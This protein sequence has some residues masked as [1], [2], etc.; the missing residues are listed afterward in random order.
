MP[1][2]RCHEQSGLVAGGADAPDRAAYSVVER[3]PGVDDRR[4]ISGIVLVIRD[5]LRWPDAPKDCGP[6]KTIHNR[7]IRCSRPGAFNRIFA[8]LATKGGRPDRQMIDATHLK[9]HRT[10][11]SLLEQRLLPDV[12]DGPEAA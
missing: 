3:V 2:G 1:R 7:F 10:A 6:H 9:A 11:A 8:A 12:S 4:V 5:G